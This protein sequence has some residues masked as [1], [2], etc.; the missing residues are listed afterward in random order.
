MSFV[1][2]ARELVSMMRMF[3]GVD[4]DR[5][6]ELAT[7]A[8]V[9]ADIAQGQFKEGEVATGM[10]IAGGKLLARYFGRR[11]AAVY[12]RALANIIERSEGKAV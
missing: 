4:T 8:L 5:S 12:L 3:G 6:A 10:A 11:K 9:F 7:S 2:K 1:K